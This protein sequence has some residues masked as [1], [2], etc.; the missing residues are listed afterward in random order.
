MTDKEIK[1]QGKADYQAWRKQMD[2]VKK[3]KQDRQYSLSQWTRKV[4]EGL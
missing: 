1:D 3:L 2:I 4:E